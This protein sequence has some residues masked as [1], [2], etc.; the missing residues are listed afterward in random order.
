MLTSVQLL[1]L[2]SRNAAS[3]NRQLLKRTNCTHI[4]YAAEMSPMC[5]E[6]QSVTSGLSCRMC[7]SFEELLAASIKV[8]SYTKKFDEAVNDPVLVLHSSGT[9]GEELLAVEVVF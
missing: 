9:S 7:P 3:Q 2:G 4:L 5:E 6:L 1:L 8:Y